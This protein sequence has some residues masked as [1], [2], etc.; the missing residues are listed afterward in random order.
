MDLALRTLLK[1]HPNLLLIGPEDES[2]SDADQLEKDGE[3]E[4]EHESSTRIQAESEHEADAV[5]PS[6]KHAISTILRFLSSLLHN[7]YNKSVFNS[8]VEMTTLLAAADDE[9]ASAALEV[10]ASLAMPVQIHRLGVPDISH[11]VNAFNSSKS[12]VTYSR[13]MMLAKGWGSKG[14]GLGLAT[15]VITDDSHS[16]QGSLPEYGGL[17]RFECLP[18]SSNKLISVELSSDDI[19]LNGLSSNNLNSDAGLVDR[20]VEKKRKT[21]SKIIGGPASRETRS[22]SHLFFHCLEKI[23][24]RKNI[25][26][27]RLFDLLVHIRLAKSFHSRETRIFAVERRL[28]ALLTVLYVHPCNDVLA[29]YFHAQPEL[30]AELTDLVRPTVSQAAVSSSQSRLRDSTNDGENA[31]VDK[32]KI[33]QAT[34]ES[35]VLSSASIPYTVRTLAVEVLSALVGRKDDSSSGISQ[36]AKQVNVLNELGVAKGQFLGL[37]PTLIRYSLASLNSVVVDLIGRNIEDCNSMDVS[38]DVDISKDKDVAM[39]DELGLQLGIGFVDVTK[40]KL[41]IETIDAEEKALEFISCV[42]SLTYAVVSSTTGT[43]SLT[44]C[45]LIPALVSTISLYDQ[46]E[47]KAPNQGVYERKNY[48]SALFKFIMAQSIQTLEAAI[49]NNS[50]ALAAF[51]ELNGIEML[52]K[53]LH[54]EIAWIESAK[55]QSENSIHWNLQGSDRVLL[56]SSLNCLTIIFHL[57]ETS[58]RS[59][60]FRLT[61]SAVLK[62][63]EMTDILI[64]IMRNVSLYC[65]TL[66]SLVMTFLGDTMNADPRVVH[67]VYQSGLADAFFS[68]MKSKTDI[69]PNQF[70]KWYEPTIPPS[71]EL[72][73]AIPNVI[74]A[75][76]LTEEG[77][78]KIAEVNPFPDLLAILCTPKFVMPKSR[79]MASDVP[80][81]I[82]SSLDEMMRH[83]PSLKGKILNAIVHFIKRVSFIGEDLVNRELKSEEIG[84]DSLNDYRIQFMQYAHSVIQILDQVLQNDEHCEPFADAGGVPVL[85]RIHPL[86]MLSGKQFLAHVSTQ[87]SPSVAIL[88]HSTTALS[89]TTAIKRVASNCSGNKVFKAVKEHTIQSLETLE[90]CITDW[91]KSS[92]TEN[93]AGASCFNDDDV[94]NVSGILEPVPN[95]PMHLL[96]DMSLNSL[97]SFL[98][99]IVNIEWVT[100]LLASILRMTFNPDIRFRGRTTWLD[101][102][103]SVDFHN[104]LDRLSLLYQSAMHEVC[105]IRS[106]EEY[107]NRNDKRWL[108]PGECDNHPAVYKLRIVCAEGA[109]VRDGIDIDS[110]ASVGS[111]EMGEEVLAYDRC[112]NGSGIMRYK[113]TKGWVSEQTRGQGREPISEV[114]EVSG[115]A[116]K[117]SAPL[118]KDPK[119][120]KAIEFGIPDLCAISASILSRLHNSQ[121]YLYSSLSRAVV[122]GF[123]TIT[124]RTAS[125]QEN[126]SETYVGILIRKL[127]G[128]LRSNFDLQQTSSSTKKADLN[129]GGR[130]LFFGNMLNILHCCIYEERREKQILNVLIFCNLLV[131]DGFSEAFFIPNLESFEKDSD[132]LTITKIPDS[133]FYKAIRFVLSYGL[134]DMKKVYMAIDTKETAITFQR[135]SKIVASSFPS[136][137]SL[138]RRLTSQSLLIDNNVGLFLSKMKGTEFMSCI[139]GDC[140]EPDKILENKIFSFRQHAFARY[141]HCTIG[142]IT[143]ELWSDQNLKFAPPHVLYPIASLVNEVFVSLDNSCKSSSLNESEEN[144]RTVHGMSPWASGLR[145][146]SRINPSRS[147]QGNQA[148]NANANENESSQDF[149]PSAETFQRMVDMGFSSEQAQQAIESS[150]SNNLEVAM[151]Y[152]LSLPPP[153][154]SAN[155]ADRDRNPSSELDANVSQNNQTENEG[156][157]ETNNESKEGEKVT[158]DSKDNEEEKRQPPKVMTPAELKETAEKRIDDACV[159]FVKKCIKSLINCVVSS[160]TT[161]IEGPSVGTEAQSSNETMQFESK[162]FHIIVCKVLLDVCKRY[163][164]ERHRIFDQII[165]CLINSLEKDIK[166]NCTVDVSSERAVASICHSLVLFSRAIPRLRTSILKNNVMSSLLQCLKTFCSKLK[167]TRERNQ[168]LWPCWI[169]PCMLLFD[170]MAEPMTLDGEKSAADD[171]SSSSRTDWN[172]VTSEHKRQQLSLTKVSKKISTAIDKTKLAPKKNKVKETKETKNNNTSNEEKDGGAITPTVTVAASTAA[173]TSTEANPFANIPAYSPLLN[174]DMAESFLTISL[175]LLRLQQSKTENKEKNTFFIPPMIMHAI[176]LTL[177]KILRSQKLSS[178]CLRMGGAELLLS[179][180]CKSRFGGHLSLISLA[181]RRMIEDESTLQTIMESKIRS[182]IVKLQKKKNRGSQPE[183]KDISPRIFVENV[184]SLICRDPIIFLRAAATSIKLVPDPSDSKKLCISLL[185]ADDRAKHTKSLT[186]NL[187]LSGQHNNPQPVNLKSSNTPTSSSKRGRQLKG[188]KQHTKVLKSKSPHRSSRKSLKKEKQD[189]YITISG[190]TANHVTSQVLTAFLRDYDSKRS[191]PEISFLS[192]AE[193]LEMI[194]D[195]LLKVPACAT[196]VH[197]FQLPSQVPIEHAMSGCK[198]PHRNIVNFLLHEL[199]SLPRVSPSKDQD[200]DMFSVTDKEKTKESFMKTKISQN[201]AR[202]L[203]VLV[204]RA[205]EGRRRV[206]FELSNA[207]RAELAEGTSIVERSNT[208]SDKEMWAFNSW[209]ELCHGLAAPKRVNSSHDSETAMSFE[210]VKVMQECGMAHALMR[211]IQRLNMEHPLAAA[212]AAALLRPLEMFTRPTMIDAIKLMAKKAEKRVDS[213]SDDDGVIVDAFNV[214]ASYNND[215]SDN[216]LSGRDDEIENDVEMEDEFDEM[217]DDSIIMSDED[218]EEDSG[219]DDSIE[220]DEDS[221]SEDDDESDDESTNEESEVSDNDMEGDEESEIN[222]DEADENMEALD[223]I[224][225]EDPANL[226]MQVDDG[227]TD[228]DFLEVNEDA[229]DEAEGNV[230]IDGDLDGEGWTSIEAGLG[231]MFSRHGASLVGRPRN[232]NNNPFMI[233]ETVIGNILRSGGLHMDALAEIEDTLGIRISTTR[234]SDG[235]RFGSRARADLEINTSNRE[236]AT[237]PNSESNTPITEPI[238]A[239]PFIHQSSPPENLFHSF[240]NNGRVGEINYMDYQYGGQ[241]LGTGREFFDPLGVISS[242]ETRTSYS[243]ELQTPATYE[244]QLFPRGTAASTQTQPSFVTHNLIAAIDLPPQNA[245]L[246]I[247][248]HDGGDSVRSRNPDNIFE[249]NY[250]PWTEIHLGSRGGPITILDRTAENRERRTGESQS[251]GRAGTDFSLAFESA[252]TSTILNTARTLPTQAQTSQSQSRNIASSSQPRSNTSSTDTSQN[253]NM[254]P[255]NEVDSSNERHA[256]DDSNSLSDGENVA[257]SLASALT[258]SNNDSTN[259]GATNNEAS[260]NNDQNEME[261]SGAVNSNNASNSE[262]QQEVRIEERNSMDI[263]VND[264]TNHVEA[265][266]NDDVSNEDVNMDESNTNGTDNNESNNDEGV[267]NEGNDEVNGNEVNNEGNDEANGDGVNNEGD[268]EI[269]SEREEVPVLNCPPGIDAEVFSQLSIEMQQ[270]IIQQHEATPENVAAQLDATSGLDPEALAALPEDMR[271]E[272]I[273]QEQNER[274]LRNQLETP[275]DP[276]NAEDMDNASFIASLA[277]DL[278]REILL[279]AEDSVLNSLPPD[280]IAEAQILRE[281][282]AASSRQRRDIMAAER[283]ESTVRRFRPSQPTENTAPSQSKPKK[284]SKTGKIRVDIDREYITYEPIGENKYGP[285]VTSSTIKP[286][287][288][289]MFLLSPVRPQKLLQKLFQNFCANAEIRQHLIKAFVALLVDESAHALTIID[290]I[291]ITTQEEDTSKMVVPFPPTHLLGVSPNMDSGVDSSNFNNFY[292]RRNGNSTATSIASNLP[293]SSKCSTPGTSIPPV[294]ARRIIVALIFLSKNVAM[295]AV[296]MLGN[297]GV[298]ENPTNDEPCLDSLLGLLGTETYSQSSSNLDD[299]LSLIENLCVPLSQIPVDSDNLSEVPQKDIDAAKEAGKMWIDVPHTIVSTQKLHLLCATLKLESCK[300]GIFVKVNNIAKRLS[301]VAANRDC[302]LRELASVAQSLGQDALHDLKALRI[303]LNQAV[304]D[305]RHMLHSSKQNSEMSGKGIPSTTVTLSTSSSELKLLRVL[306]SLHSLCSVAN[307]DGSSKKSEGISVVRKDLVSLLENIN[308]SPIWEQLTGCLREVSILEG[309]SDSSDENDEGNSDEHNSGKKLQNSVAGLLSR[310]L[311]TI[312]AFFVVNASVIETSE[313]SSEDSLEDGEDLQRLVG[314]QKLVD[315]VTVNKVLINAL[316]RSSPSLLD[317]GLRAMVRIPRCRAFMDFD[318]KRH[319]F[320]TQVRR[321]RQTASRRHGNLRLSI[322]RQRVF[323]DAYHQLRHWNAEEMR[324]RLHITFVNEEGVDAGGLSRE[325]FGILAKEMFNPNYALFTSTEDGCTFQPNPHSSINPDHLSYFQFVGRI[326]GKAVADGFLLDAHFTRSLYKHMLGLKVSLIPTFQPCCLR[327]FI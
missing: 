319:W 136:A 125:N 320:R 239:L 165:K 289:L 24:G 99:N 134:K 305:H 76:A 96:Q 220:S 36:I 144:D 240:G 40:P 14:S 122:L 94:L 67:Y 4:E 285:L 108:A 138:L 188:H 182:T 225:L 77:R 39:E 311:P 121:C 255:Q 156:Q 151:E 75:L 112:V 310:F 302:I 287:I 133:G 97:A 308:L 68:M 216:P 213:K 150:Q 191:T 160:T 70:E 224:E 325:F 297:F 123:K 210:V 261:P 300:D 254:P 183:T 69:P 98:R 324:G 231:N 82:G 295:S 184:V 66:T 87:S 198:V 159:K 270:E 278:R 118:V 314:G 119:T 71:Q 243:D 205:G 312:E 44:D 199:L 193:S 50:Q 253:D 29:G 8:V 238:G 132:Q 61:P 9:I 241:P 276:S 233:A 298:S 158:E 181:L 247:T 42:L 309:V 174:H 249:R 316:L 2:K 222:I 106:R 143:E 208:Q 221:E 126:I 226:E 18:S 63:K 127:S 107:D 139:A 91:K 313:Q 267:N 80:A 173:E 268:N 280:I 43:A 11:N 218:S 321:L 38:E 317:K 180:Q 283:P 157:S 86:L 65:G 178:V 130:A 277:P 111:L 52:L 323:E 1:K 114:F 235:P 315:F 30:C 282:A 263:D 264:E 209:G 88:T 51:H 187:R 131:H 104:M 110:C 291:G 186:D 271:R 7:A 49:S 177:T 207:L 327:A 31:T 219:T 179:I 62:K 93:D 105:R 200:P 171:K 101:E 326:V 275:A 25:T 145:F 90:E 194:G 204:A 257:S 137:L 48:L 272:I 215:N 95:V 22:T 17:V 273:E 149:R 246:T 172:R 175:Q 154:T 92:G 53:S 169:A 196:V 266:N 227:D 248:H 34:I 318:V 176:L 192:T 35:I 13:L 234:P 58:S 166:G 185:P 163:P 16:G 290:A 262:S 265:N 116:S 322:R 81:M 197:N 306:Q 128:L 288:S 135:Q 303:R 269:Q 189:R 162:N 293:L 214:D 242:Q 301:K 5:P 55:T 190:S 286:L 142:H 56:N 152:A 59:A 168:S 27:E 72:I 195:L 279:T 124:S 41:Q 251:V 147:S 229:E 260:T 57:Q 292:R 32:T 84:D 113:T 230:Q 212:T 237:N 167:H 232:I 89:I 20:Q 245:L 206:I 129:E 6:I 153:P 155:Q 170:V 228:D 79:C 3:N 296:D 211:G 244:V 33:K 85:L 102:R 202:L 281:R 217:E 148:A 274:R 236:R 117:R 164:L 304:Q 161:I 141:V 78:K 115:V 54:A 15:T 223:Q 299:L 10:L 146:R 64:E 256:Q 37:L 120:C 45:G 26:T 294:V 46:V 140:N 259:D 21:T 203:V 47:K 284:R 19:C 23:G 103:T 28:H 100:Q 60:S 201:A 250:N 73:V 252:L 258:L 307:E 83:V 74:T 109:I 12:S